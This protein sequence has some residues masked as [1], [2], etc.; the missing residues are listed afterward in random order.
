M[1][2]I[3]IT[4]LM[5]L[6]AFCLCLMGDY[7]K[8]YM[9]ITLPIMFLFDTIIIYTYYKLGMTKFDIASGVLIGTISKV[10][11]FLLYQKYLRDE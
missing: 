5:M 8:Q 7:L 10:I 6:S 4:F 2:I 11:I 3:L 1:T 9:V